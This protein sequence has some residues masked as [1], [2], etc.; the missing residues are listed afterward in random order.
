MINSPIL[1]RMR[2][3]SNV[4]HTDDYIDYDTLWI[5]RYTN[6][7][8]FINCIQRMVTPVFFDYRNIWS[9]RLRRQLKLARMVAQRL[10]QYISRHKNLF[11]ALA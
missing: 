7:D 2:S 10:K 6:Y 4:N 1:M 3:C 8:N 5:N 9:R 11:S